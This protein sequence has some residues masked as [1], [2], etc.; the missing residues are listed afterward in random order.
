MSNNH[1][2]QRTGSGR[3]PLYNQPTKVIRVPESAVEDIKLFLNQ[4]KNDIQSI[5][6]VSAQK[7]VSIPFALEKVFAGPPSNTEGYIEKPLDMNTLLIK[8]EI[9]TFAVRVA[10]LSML[11]AG[12][13]IDDI[14]MV[15]R[16]LQAIHR[17][18]V[19]ALIDNEFTV[20]RL[21]IENGYTWLQ[22]ENPDF[23][24]IHLK[25]GQELL[26]WG[27]V[28]YTIKSLKRHN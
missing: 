17:D 16:S 8:N 18:I 22:A 4:F 24:D 27:V 23:P 3:K 26:I 12:I 21:M 13:H 11:N 7:H 10:S 28:T 25:E 15:D 5:Q 20:K 14:L 19:I 1:G 9:A 6:Q 2:G